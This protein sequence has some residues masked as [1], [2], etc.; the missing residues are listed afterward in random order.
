MMRIVASKQAA[1]RPSGRSAATSMRT[2]RRLE[3]LTGYLFIAPTLF[4]FAIFTL[5][6]L[7]AGLGLSLF[8]FD[9]FSAPQF[10]GL[11][12]F[13]HLMADA[14]IFK[15]IGN[16]LYFGIGIIALNLTWAL[17]LALALNSRMPSIFRVVFRGVFFFPLLTSGAVMAMVW[18][19]LLSTDLGLVNYFLGLL[20]IP[21]APWLGSSQWVR[22]AIIFASVWQGVGFNMIV[23]LAGMQG[24]PRELY[25]AAQ[26]DGAGRVAGFRFVTIPLLTPTLFFILVR[27]VIIVLQLFD[28]PFSLT[29]GGP[30]DASRT[31]VMYIYEEGFQAMRQGYASAI[32]LIL[33]LVILAVTIVQFAE[34]RRWVY[35]R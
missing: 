32:A 19:Y 8:R 18:Q 6:A 1:S 31:L 30:G 29:R 24:I 23:L 2:Y 16:T 7:L 28:L 26:I 27:E 9:F 13:T 15:I 34:S 20:G 14:R 4:N 25:E 11:N 3:A 22:P 17:A 33:F 35:Y 21:K 12:N 5:L 10:I